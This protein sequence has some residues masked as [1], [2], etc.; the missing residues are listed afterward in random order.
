[1]ST[2]VAK[3]VDNTQLFRLGETRENT[4]ELQRDLIKP[5]ELAT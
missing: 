2:A 3:F 4:E 5:D 1:M